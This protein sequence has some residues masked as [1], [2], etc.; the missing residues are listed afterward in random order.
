MNQTLLFIVAL[1]SPVVFVVTALASWFE[2]G[3]RPARVKKLAVTST[4]ISIA[5][6]ALSGFFVFHYGMLETPLIGAEGLGI[7]LRLD[8]ISILM[9]TMIAL[10]GF[11]VVLYSL[12]YLDGDDR[13][14]AFIGRLAATIA[15][16]QLLVLSGNLG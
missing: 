6:A 16:V 15:S 3:L 11:V 9:F 12:N 4:W 13:Q 2:P 1:A 10:I 7:S 14:G 8:S 5:I